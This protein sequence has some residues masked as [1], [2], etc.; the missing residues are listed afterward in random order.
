MVNSYKDVIL[1]I[2]ISHLAQSGALAAKKMAGEYLGAME[3]PRRQAPPPP[4][5][6]RRQAGK[7]APRYTPRYWIYH[8][9]LASSEDWSY[10]PITFG[11]LLT[12]LMPFILLLW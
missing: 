10:W 7:A 3:S 11:C 6:D 2:Q 12:N 9:T 8:S 4:P 1:A 5:G